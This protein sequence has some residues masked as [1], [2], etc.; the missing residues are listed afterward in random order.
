MGCELDRTGSKLIK[1]HSSVE[2]G[3]KLHVHYNQEIF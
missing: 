3:I 1:E 2:K